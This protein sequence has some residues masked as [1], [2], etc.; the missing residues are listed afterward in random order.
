MYLP[1]NAF[2]IRI[3]SAHFPSFTFSSASS[4]WSSESRISEI[5]SSSKH[6]FEFVAA[7]AKALALLGKRAETLLPRLEQITP[8]HV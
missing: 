5:L 4:T 3:S 7:A 8:D 6:C 2:F 1:W